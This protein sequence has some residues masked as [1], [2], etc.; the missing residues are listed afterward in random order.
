VD[1]D[2][3]VGCT[4]PLPGRYDVRV[5]VQLGSRAADLVG[6]FSTEVF[7]PNVP[8]PIPWQQGLYVIMSGEVVTRPLPP[9]AWARGDYHVDVAFIN[10]TAQTLPLVSPTISFLVYKRGETL[11]CSGKSES[12]EL[13][14]TL[15][16]ATVHV[17]KAPVACA[18]SE[19]GDYDIVGKLSVAGTPGE[20]EAGRVGLKVTRD[21]W[22]L[23]G[24]TPYPSP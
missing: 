23:F 7:G 13:P 20:I 4:M 10:G 17:A 11:P 2:R 18:P 22:L 5:F 6:A 15:A 14:A 9:E 19:V 1:I 21:Q 8:R 24:P 12:L 16:P 3:P